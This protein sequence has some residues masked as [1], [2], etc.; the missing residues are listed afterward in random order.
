MHFRL[1]NADNNDI[2]GNDDIALVAKRVAAY[3]NESPDAEQ[4]YFKTLQSVTLAEESGVE[5]K[6]FIEN[7]RKFFSKQMLK[8]V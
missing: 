7:A 1:L 6:E 4:C 3:Q 8:D 2:L 5:E